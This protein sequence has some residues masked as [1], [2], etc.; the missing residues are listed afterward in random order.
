MTISK[1]EE[2]Q[3]AFLKLWNKIPLHSRD[4]KFGINHAEW[5]AVEI[6]QLA[7]VL[8]QF[9]HRFSRDK[10]DLGHCAALPFRIELKPSTRPIKQ[11]PY[12]RNPDINAKVQYKL[13]NG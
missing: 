3:S 6:S 13:V 5:G 4:V 1:S 2:Q 11:R 10:T 8:L 9:E 12:R 7:D